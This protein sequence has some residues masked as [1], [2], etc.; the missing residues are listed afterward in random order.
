MSN[1]PGTEILNQLPI[2]Q[3]LSFICLSSGLRLPLIPTL[4]SQVFYF[5]PLLVEIIKFLT[6][7]SAKLKTRYKLWW[8]PQGTDGLAAG[9][10]DVNYLCMCQNEMDWYSSVSYSLKAFDTMK[11]REAQTRFIYQIYRS[12]SRMRSP[13][14]ISSLV[15]YQG[16]HPTPASL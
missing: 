8:Y 11:V 1:S 5:V 7:P 6:L 15:K 10:G 9:G 4:P 14:E 12:C 13:T 16:F 3:G 2:F